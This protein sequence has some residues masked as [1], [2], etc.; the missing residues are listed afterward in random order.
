MMVLHTIKMKKPEKDFQEIEILLKMMKC[1]NL[2]G[3]I[4]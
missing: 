2:D 4:K 1:V 3:Y